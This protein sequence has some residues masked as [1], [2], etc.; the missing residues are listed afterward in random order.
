MKMLSKKKQANHKI[1][2]VVRT[3]TAVHSS[4]I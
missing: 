3:L 1:F 2:K 4:A